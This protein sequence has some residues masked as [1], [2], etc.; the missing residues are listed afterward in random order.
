MLT[1]AVC[2]ASTIRSRKPSSIRTPR[3][4]RRSASRASSMSGGVEDFHER[5]LDLGCVFAPFFRKAEGDGLGLGLATCRE[6]VRW[7]GGTIRMQSRPAQG[8]VVRLLLPAASPP[9]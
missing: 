6:L 3:H 2:D 8:T 9:H 4:T 7:M 5:P 1:A